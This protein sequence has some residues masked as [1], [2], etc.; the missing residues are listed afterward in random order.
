[1]TNSAESRRELTDPA[2]YIAEIAAHVGDRDPID[3]LTE[4]PGLLRAIVSES[5]DALL[6]ARPY[7]GKWSPIEIFGHY[8]D[9]ELVHSNRFRA[10]YGD[11]NP[12]LVG[13]DQDQWV[14]R[15]DYQHAEANELVEDFASVRAINLKL[16]KRFTAEDLARP[17]THNE[18]GP[19]TLGPYLKMYA[20]H[21]LYH[22][23]QLRDYLAAA[24]SA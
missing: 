21:D 20:G 2:R 18:R 7:E 15:L 9:C 11:D 12:T 17:A 6:R 1:M 3:V 24:Q 16:F 10:F 14:A 4:T 8:L 23:A 13:M 19:A 22:L 5:S